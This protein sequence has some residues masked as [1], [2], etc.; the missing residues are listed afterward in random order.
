MQVRLPA[1]PLRTCYC[2]ES[3]PA[4]NVIIVVRSRQNHAVSSA[5]PTTIGE[6]RNRSREVL[7]CGHQRRQPVTLP[8]SSSRH[9]S[10]RQR[11]PAT[12][13][14]SRTRPPILP[15]A[16]SLKIPSPV[17]GI[18]SKGHLPENRRECR[19]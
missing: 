1:N 16:R 19:Q 2:P 3:G 5:T 6:K 18:L 14:S 11:G 4:R 10:K 17:P 15:P 9:S 8:H 7:R 13:S 12:Y